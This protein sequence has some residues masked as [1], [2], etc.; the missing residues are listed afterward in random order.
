MTKQEQFIVDY[1]KKNIIDRFE[2]HDAWKKGLYELAK[3]NP[4][5]TV[6]DQKTTPGTC[7]PCVVFECDGY[8]AVGYLHSDSLRPAM[9]LGNEYMSMDYRIMLDVLR[10]HFGVA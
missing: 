2:I 7:C 6:R 9:Y 5:A 1:E 10:G 8:R 4:C 3:N